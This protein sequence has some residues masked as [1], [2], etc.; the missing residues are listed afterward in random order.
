MVTR[1]GPC[2]YPHTGTRTLAQYAIRVRPKTRTMAL[3]VA[4]GAPETTAISSQ[5]ASVLRAL[6]I[7]FS[8]GCGGLPL[9][10]PVL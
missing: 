2:T 7:A 3:C 5:W 4:V 6:R 8:P 9:L 10:A 1:C